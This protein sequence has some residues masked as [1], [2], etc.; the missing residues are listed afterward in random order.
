MAQRSASGFK[1]NID[2]QFTTN[3]SG[4]NTAA[5][6]RSYLGQDIADS[7][8]NKTDGGTIAG[9]VGVGTTPEAPLDVKAVSSTVMQFRGNANEAANK[10]TLRIRDIS[11]GDF[12]LYDATAAAYRMYFNSVGNLGVG[13]TTP[14][15]TLHLKAGT[16]TA[17]TAP[18]KLTTGTALT[19]PEDGALEYHSSHLYF[20]IGS[21]RYQLDQQTGTALDSGT[22]TPTGTIGVNVSA[23]TPSQSQYMRV[24]NTV[25]VSGKL[26]F[27]TSASGVSRFTISVPVASNFGALEDAAGVATGGDGTFGVIAI[28]ADNPSDTVQFSGN[29]PSAG[30]WTSVL[31]TFTYQVI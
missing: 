26:S 12:S 18:L 17:N 15:A 9:N 19:A 25:T 14:T 31:F 23:V 10:W 27:T 11:E 30:T 28:Q 13:T 2:A 29:A 8:L 7:F 21:T 3:G 24:G 4:L 6:V 20:T 1:T 5:K 16:A 22:Y